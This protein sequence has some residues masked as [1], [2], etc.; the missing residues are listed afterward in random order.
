MQGVWKPRKIAN[1]DYFLDETPLS[2]IGKV[3]GVAVEI[4]TMDEG[5]L[6]DNILVANDASA[7]E[8]KRE[9]LWV[10]KKEAEVGTLPHPNSEYC[11]LSKYLEQFCSMYWRPV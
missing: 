2:N 3:G 7:A 4:W 9:A 1:P 5:Y 6:F 11:L 10:P 8:A